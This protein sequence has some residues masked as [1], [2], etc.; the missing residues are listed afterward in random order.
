MSRKSHNGLIRNQNEIGAYVPPGHEG[1]VN[2]RLVDKTFCG[3]FEMNLGIVQPGGEASPHLHEDEHQVIY[4]LDGSAEVVLGDDPAVV[5]G[6]GSV[7]EIPPKLLHAVY[8]TG[9]RPLKAVILYSPPLPPR[10]E[11]PVSGAAS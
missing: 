8:V 4:I 7:I 3:A 1:T 6:P 5:C 11:I 2:I 9:E 10:E